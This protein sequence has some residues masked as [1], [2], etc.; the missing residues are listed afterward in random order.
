MMMLSQFLEPA[1]IL[2]KVPSCLL[3]LSPIFPDVAEQEP[4]VNLHN[5]ITMFYQTTDLLHT[6]T[7][8]VH[9]IIRN[10]FSGERLQSARQIHVLYFDKV[11]VI[12]SVL[13]LRQFTIT[14]PKNLFT[15]TYWRV[16]IFI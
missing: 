16:Q 14:S 10:D 6:G 8:I 15:T 1:V 2:V 13:P 11:G 5:W 9:K 12:K 3:V 7:S 4:A